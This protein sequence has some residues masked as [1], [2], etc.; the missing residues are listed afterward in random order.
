MSAV[1]QRFDA[2]LSRADEVLRERLRPSLDSLP[3]SGEFIA[4]HR[5]GDM[6]E[7]VTEF[8]GRRRPRQG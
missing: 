5:V 4:R 2:T 6:G 7:K 1:Q 8:C 3:P